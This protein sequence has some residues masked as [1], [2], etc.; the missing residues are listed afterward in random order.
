M[1]IW[2]H[3]E[4]TFGHLGSIATHKKDLTLESNFSETNNSSTKFMRSRS[5]LTD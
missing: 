4:D 5:I 2:G 1:A 3:L